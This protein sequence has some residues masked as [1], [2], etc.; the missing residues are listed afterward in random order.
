MV[1]VKYKKTGVGMFFS[2]INMIRIL[3]RLLLVA[4]ITLEKENMQQGDVYFSSPTR[5]GVESLCEYMVIETKENAK[6]V[7]FKLE[8]ILPSWLEIVKGADVVRKINIASLNAYAKYQISF[9]EYKS[10]KP[11]IEEFLNKDKITVSYMLH[12]ETKTLNAKKG[13]Y[14]YKL[15][16]NSLEVVAKVEENSIRID[17]FAM[18]LLKFLGKSKNDF[19]VLKTNLYTLD[20]TGNL[21]DIDDVVEILNSSKGEIK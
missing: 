10:C 2:Q 21:V 1:V 5:V 4:G 15:N 3:K 17:E 12:G 7:C 6:T 16:E 9:D 13:I 18:A 8:N 19:K 11:K 14:L 20:K